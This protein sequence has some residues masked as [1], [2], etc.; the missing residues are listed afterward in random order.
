MAA[1]RKKSTED[2]RDIVIVFKDVCMHCDISPW[3]YSE[4][5]RESILYALQTASKEIHIDRTYV[6]FEGSKFEKTFMYEEGWDSLCRMLADNGYGKRA[7]AEEKR[8][9][10]AAYRM[11]IEC[12]M[13]FFFKDIGY[14]VSGM[15]FEVKKGT[16]FSVEYYPDKAKEWKTYPGA[17]QK[18]DRPDAV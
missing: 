8:I 16:S 1:R 12:Y 3:M 9:M 15:K 4:K 10:E 5:D 7:T 18:W 6:E 17:W 2:F 13:E 14:D 11:M